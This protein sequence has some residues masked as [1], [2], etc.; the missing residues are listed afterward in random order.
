MAALRE[1]VAAGASSFY[2][3]FSFGASVLEELVV[4]VV[5]VGVKGVTEVVMETSMLKEEVLQASA[6]H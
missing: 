4:V 6:S 3:P 1:A 5:V 2:L